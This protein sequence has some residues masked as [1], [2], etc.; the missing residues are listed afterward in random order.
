MKATHLSR[1]TTVRD[2][3]WNFCSFSRSN[4]GLNEHF[5]NKQTRRCA[6]WRC[7]SGL[8]GTSKIAGIRNHTSPA[9][10]GPSDSPDYSRAWH[11]CSQ[12]WQGKLQN[13]CHLSNDKLNKLVY[14]VIF[15]EVDVGGGK[16]AIVIFVPV[17]QLRQ[18][19]KIQVRLVRELEKKFSGKHIV[20]IAQV[21]L[22][23]QGC[24]KTAF[25]IWK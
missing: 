15:Q 1:S 12:Q 25:A 6:K 4:P 19:Q 7:I 13:T 24:C 2:P 5:K 8:S 14:A 21:I 11:A 18:F 3:N 9:S 23:F 10:S 20:F 22:N 16:K 17:P